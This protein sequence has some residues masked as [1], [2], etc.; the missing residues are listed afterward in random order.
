MSGILR[1]VISNM[2]T[3][4]YHQFWFALLISIFIMFAWKKYSSI[5]EAAVEWLTWFRTETS[6]RR[7]F[8]LTFYT[9]MILFRTVLNRNM[10]A[11]PL[12]NVIGVW[13]LYD[14]EGN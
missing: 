9:S 14:A 7:M 11:N 5:K 12:S 6:F 10:W 1:T 3:K 2:L 13:R 4:L 8:F